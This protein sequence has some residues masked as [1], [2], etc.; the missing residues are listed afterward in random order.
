MDQTCGFES[1]R[2]K[3]SIIHSPS[4][5]SIETQR[6]WGLDLTWHQTNSKPGFEEGMKR[7]GGSN[8]RRENISKDRLKK[9]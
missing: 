9:P 1:G 5:S 7:T 8:G 3:F 4:L 2:Y 6:L